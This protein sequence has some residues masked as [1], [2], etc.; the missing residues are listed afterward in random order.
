MFVPST[1]APVNRDYWFLKAFEDILAFFFFFFL[2]IIQKK[3]FLKKFKEK[4]DGRTKVMQRHFGWSAN[5]VI[6][7]TWTSL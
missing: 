1:L 4:F 6:Q 2:N 5:H 7:V 3:I